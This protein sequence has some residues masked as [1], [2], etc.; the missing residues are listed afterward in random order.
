MYWRLKKCVWYDFVWF[1]MMRLNGPQVLRELKLFAKFC[2]S[3]SRSER[4][5]F[6][7]VDVSLLSCL[8][9]KQK[10]T[11]W[12]D[13]VQASARSAAMAFDRLKALD[14]YLE[15]CKELPNFAEILEQQSVQLVKEIREVP[16]LELEAA[17]PL[18]AL[19]QQNVLWTA[20]LKE[21][22]CQAIHEKVQ[23]SMVG[24]LVKDRVNLQNY[25]YFPHYLTQGEWDTL[26]SSSNFGLKINTLMERCYRLGLR[27]PTE[28]TYAMLTTVLLLR[29]QDRFMDPLQLRSSYL[30]TKQ[31]A[32]AFLGHKQKA[33]TTQGL[34]MHQY[35]PPCPK[36]L[37]SAR[38]T[39]AFGESKPA[40]KFPDGV[41]MEYLQSL[42]ALV[43]E[44]GNSASL[45]LQ[46]K[47]MQHILQPWRIL[48]MCQWDTS[49]WDTWAWEFI[50]KDFKLRCHTGWHCQP[51]QHLCRLLNWP[52]HRPRN[53]SSFRYQ[54]HLY[55]HPLLRRLQNQR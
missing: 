3:S 13:F 6:T 18:I 45:Q 22:I 39:C 5:S 43:P 10:K 2:G 12:K 52:C 11:C 51:L 37:E 20:P 46:S 49:Q 16:K 30:T 4:F 9:K 7:I 32:K 41:S 8:S 55:Q 21:T 42:M 25:I 23:Q 44:R 15:Q 31:M 24:K 47:F 38:W 1:N 53:T 17:A 26:M 48:G 27:N 19:V 34:E 36:S 28:D 50:F 54:A 35:L 33:G 29:D 14:N 40:A